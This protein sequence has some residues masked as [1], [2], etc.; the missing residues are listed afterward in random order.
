MIDHHVDGD[1]RIHPRRVAAGG[2]HRLAHG[3]EIAQQG[4]ARGIGHQHPSRTEADFLVAGAMHEPV[5]QGQQVVLIARLAAA[6]AVFQ[7]YSQADRQARGLD[8]AGPLRG[9]QA[10]EVVSPPAGIEAFEQIGG[11]AG[12]DARR[13]NGTDGESP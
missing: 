10:G 11:G 7:E 9:A 3:G 12:G 6:Q 2:A 4:N 5:A 8:Q 1:Q 13:R